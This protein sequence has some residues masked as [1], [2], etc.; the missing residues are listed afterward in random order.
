MDLTRQETAEITSLAKGKAL[1]LNV[2]ASIVVLDSSGRIKA[3]E[4]SSYPSGFDIL[5]KAITK[6]KVTSLFSMHIHAMGETITPIP[7]SY[8]LAQSSEGGLVSFSA[9]LPI[10]RNE[11]IIGYI[12]A[13]GGSASQDF[14][15]AASGASLY[16]RFDNRLN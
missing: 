2:N 16:T 3:F 11:N 8:G 6:A 10:Y 14:I 5:D 9:G 15:I 13:A 7:L 4:I 12:S 1:E